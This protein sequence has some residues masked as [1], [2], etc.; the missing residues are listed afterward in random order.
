MEIFKP[1]EFSPCAPCCAYRLFAPAAV[2]LVRAPKIVGEAV[3]PPRVAEAILTVGEPAVDNSEPEAGLRAVVD[4][5]AVVKVLAV[6]KLRVAERAGLA[7]SPG[8]A[9]GPSASTSAA[10]AVWV[11]GVAVRR[12]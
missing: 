10:W 8:A 2:K 6:A 1:G 11:E 9:A 12:T 3:G 4:L 5:R 7:G